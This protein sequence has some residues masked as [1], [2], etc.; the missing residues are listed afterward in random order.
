MIPSSRKPFDF[1]QLAA[2]GLRRGVTTGTCATAAVKAALFKLLCGEERWEIIVNLVDGTHFVNIP[3]LKIEQ[4]RQNRIKATVVKDAG[5]DPDATHLAKI[6]AIVQRNDQGKVCFKAG[7]GVGTITQPG[8]AFP[9]GDPAIN[10]VPRE[11]MKTA[12]QEILSEVGYPK[13]AGFDLEIGC[14]D[15]LKISKKTYNA[16]L[17]IVGG[18]SILG[19]TGIVEPKSLSSYLASIELYIRIAVADCPEAIVLTPGN[20]GQRFA[21]QTL[22]FPIKRIVQM[23]NFVGFS[24]DSL[25]QTL[26]EYD[27]TLPC[28]WVAGHPGKLAKLLDQV[29]DTHS[30]SS[31]AAIGAVCRAA[32]RFGIDQ[33]LVEECRQSLTVEQITRLLKADKTAPQFWR[34]VENQISTIIKN[35]T[36]LVQDVQVRLITMKG[37]LLRDTASSSQTEL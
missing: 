15:G 21:S 10:P 28:L 31:K 4:E 22:V 7:D 37:A 12:V 3:I 32:E 24:L 16:R 1:D 2:N 35:K 34:D 25:N 14:E 23:S 19:T 26:A 17:G 6:F 29:W 30:G 36:P 8:F 9:I 11:M 18:I 13:E 20:I 33:N 27:F 5:D